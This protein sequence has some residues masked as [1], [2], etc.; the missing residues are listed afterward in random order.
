[1]F[2]DDLQLT[3]IPTYDLY[4]QSVVDAEIVSSEDT[5]GGRTAIILDLSN[6][7]INTTGQGLLAK[8]IGT[9]FSWPTDVGTIL[10]LWQPSII[11][12][13]EEIYQRLSFNFLSTSLGGVGWQHIREVNLAFSSTTDLELQFD[14]GAGAFPSALGVNVPNSG[15]LV[16]KQKILIPPNKW[17]TVQGYLFSSAPFQLWVNDMEIKVRSWGSADPYRVAKPFAS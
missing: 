12:L 16:T 13:H 7:S 4:T 15:G 10:D 14:F 1:M 6:A 9:I 11:P 3:I 5:T 17:K 8:D 2:F